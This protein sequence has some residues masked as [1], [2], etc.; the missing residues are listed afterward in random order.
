MSP[1]NLL[2]GICLADINWLQ[3]KQLTLD[4]LRILRNM[5]SARQV[6][7]GETDGDQ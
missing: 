1:I 7:G 4:V 5:T 2:E 3:D 6:E